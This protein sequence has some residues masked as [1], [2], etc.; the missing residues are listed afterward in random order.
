VAFGSGAALLASLAVLRLTGATTPAAVLFAG[1]ELRWACP[2]KLWLGFDCPGC[3][4]SRSVMLALG[5]RWGEAAAMNPGGPLLV[6]GA[7]LLG[8]A[9]VLLPLWARGR[10]GDWFG[11]ALGRLRLLAGGYAG[12]TALLMLV[13]WTLR[14]I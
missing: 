9:L 6:A 1:R 11:A 10:G 7:V 8:T 4:M 5:G 2:L 13:R 3:G 12:V 14:V